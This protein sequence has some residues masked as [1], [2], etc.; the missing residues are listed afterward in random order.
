MIARDV[1]EHRRQRRAL[2]WARSLTMA[3]SLRIPK[4]IDTEILRLRPIAALEV[5]GIGV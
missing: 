3:A 1:A 4:L 2:H 5:P